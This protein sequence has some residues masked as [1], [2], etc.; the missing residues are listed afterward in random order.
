[1]R[2]AAAEEAIM[3]GSR[4]NGQQRIYDGDPAMPRRMHFPDAV[5][6]TAAKYGCGVGRCGARTVRVTGDAVRAC[7]SQIEGLPSDELILQI[8]WWDAGVPQ[9]GCCQPGQ[10]AGQIMRATALS[11]KTPAPTD[12]QILGAIAVNPCRCGSHQ[13]IHLALRAAAG[14]A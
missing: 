2:K 6:L 5:A 14:R 1:L 10:I 13:R 8:A 3:A 9:C 11:A 4:V 7:I 12:A